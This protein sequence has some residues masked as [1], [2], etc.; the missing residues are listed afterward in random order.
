MSREIYNYSVTLN[1]NNIITT[2]IL[3]IHLLPNSIVQYYPRKSVIL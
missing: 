1:Q 3:V 2:F